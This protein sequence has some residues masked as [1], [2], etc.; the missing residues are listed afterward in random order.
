MDISVK[1]LTIICTLVVVFVAGCGGSK[2]VSFPTQVSGVPSSKSCDAKGI[3]TDAAEPGTCVVSGTR[4]TVANR[5]QWLRMQGYDA[6]VASVRT[7]DRVGNFAGPNFIPNGKF[8]VVSLQAKNTGN[9]AQRFD[10]KS[11]M[12]YLLVDGTEYAEVAQAA[13]GLAGSFKA[14][15]ASIAPGDVGNGTVVFDVPEQHLANLHKA[16]SYVVFLNTDE[17]ENGYPRLGFPSLG[18]IRLWK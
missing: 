4:I 6:R 13:Q 10:P 8:V 14:D 11:N 1:R 15:R 9:Q 7:A 2:K 18:F 16:G 17:N 5:A 3:S 12:A